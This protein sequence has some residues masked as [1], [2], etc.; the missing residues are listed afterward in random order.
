MWGG[1]EQYGISPP[2]NVGLET[3]IFIPGEIP[4]TSLN[5]I[6]GYQSKGQ[7]SPGGG[8]VVDYRTQQIVNGAPFD[9][10]TPGGGQTISPR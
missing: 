8:S 9:V 3:L 10:A 7:L 1:K 6:A 5:G 2:A 4:Q